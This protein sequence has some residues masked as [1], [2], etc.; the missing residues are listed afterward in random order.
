M[1]TLF[2]SVL[3]V[4]FAGCGGDWSNNDLTFA[5]AL[6]RREDLRA[7]L[8]ASATQPLGGEGT[9][10]DELMVGDPSSA[11][12]Q[13]V[14]AA[15]D[16]NL[17]LDTLLAFVDQIRAVPPTT[18]TKDSRTWGPYADQNNEGRQ[19]QAVI[20]RNSES[21]FSWKI[22]SR[23]TNGEWLVVVSGNYNATMSARRGVGDVTVN[24]VQFRDVLNVDD[25]FKQL[26]TIEVGYMT[27]VWPQRVEMTFTFRPGAVSGLSQVGY[28]SRLQEDGSG[29]I[30]FVYDR[31]NDTNVSQLEVNAAWKPTGEGRAL[32]EVTK[33]NFTGFTVTECWG[34][35]Y[36]LTHYAESWPAGETSGPSSSCVSIDW[37]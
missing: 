21:E 34:T 17:V 5:N 16:Y 2:F 36:L 3:V 28:T 19:V 15:K 35:N 10:R 22:E 20:T 31:P 8:P 26:D 13:T 18:R 9:R 25:N 11:W 6:P 27:D 29:A 32:G 23:P 1:R 33:G 37:L 4:A 12:N 7:K 14:K 30:R 24:V